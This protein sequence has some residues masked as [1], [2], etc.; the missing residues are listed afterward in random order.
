MNHNTAQIKSKYKVYTLSKSK[1]IKS[2]VPRQT[3]IVPFKVIVFDLI[4]QK[5]KEGNR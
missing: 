1:R 2:R 5:P 4:K 3:S